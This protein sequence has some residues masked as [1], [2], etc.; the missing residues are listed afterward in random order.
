MVK[1]QTCFSA[2]S[3]FWWQAT[4]RRLFRPFCSR[5]LGVEQDFGPIVPPNLVLSLC[6]A[7]LWVEVFPDEGVSVH[8]RWNLAQ[9]ASGLHSE[10]PTLYN[11]YLQ[12]S[13]LRDQLEHVWDF[14][15]NVI[16]ITSTQLGHYFRKMPQMLSEPLGVTAEHVA[17]QYFGW[18]HSLQTSVPARELG[19]LPVVQVEVVWRTVVQG[20][21]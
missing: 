21:D 8:S 1:E 13:S 18:G 20:Q 5:N 19:P 10:V 14:V 9:V 16:H 7:S 15:Y 3:L 11:Q 2:L 4:D 17:G 6:T 12:T